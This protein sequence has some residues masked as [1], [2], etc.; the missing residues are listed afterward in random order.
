MGKK[1][2]QHA[3]PL[4][5]IARAAAHEA[6]DAQQQEALAAQEAAAE[7]EALVR[8]AHAHLNFIDAVVGILERLGDAADEYQV[9]EAKKR[10]K[11][12]L[13]F[14]AEVLFNVLEEVPPPALPPTQE[15]E[16]GA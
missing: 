11:L 15:E 2:K 4:E 8:A 3:G 7:R 1:K 6:L 12:A 9:E 13:E 16:G 14:A 5:S 10:Q